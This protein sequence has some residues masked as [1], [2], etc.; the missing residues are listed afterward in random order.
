MCGITGL[1][2]FKEPINRQIIEAMT[3][4]L[5][6][7]GPD[8]DGI[9][10]KNNIA[11]GHRRLAIID[12]ATGQQPLCNE[13]ETV[14]VTFNGEIYNYLDLRQQL[15]IAGHQFRTQSDTEVI[16]HAYE[17]WG[18][19]CV[20]KFRG[21]FAFGIVD[22]KQQKLFLARDQLGI[23]PLYYLTTPDCFAFASELQALRQ[24][25]VN[26]DIDVQA[27]DQYLWLQYIPPPKTIFQQIKKLPTA[28][29]ISITF[30]GNLS[31]PQEYWQLDFN[32]NRKKTEKEWLEEFDFILRESIKSHLVSDVPFGAFLSGGVD[33]SATVAY[34]SQLLEQPVKT[35]SIGFEEEE[36]NELNYAE[37]PAKLW[38]TE[39]YTEIVKLESL[40]VLLP[41]LVKH[42]GEPF[43]DSSA[44]PTYYVCKMARQHVTMVLSGDGGDECFAGYNT[45]KNWMA[46][47]NREEKPLWK[48]FAYPVAQMLK[49]ERYPPRHP[50]LQSWFRFITQISPD[51]RHQ[52]W[53][54]DYQGLVNQPIEVFVKEN[55]K[56]EDYAWSQKAQYIDIKT[57]LPGSILTKVDVVSM[58]N[59]LEVRTPI[60]D[61]EVF[62]FAATIPEPLNI[63]RNS[64]GDWE[65]KLLFKKLLS[66]YYEQDFLHR[67]KMGFST[68]IEKWFSQK[69]DYRKTLEDRFLSQNSR[70]HQYF[71]P[72]MLKI[73]LQQKATQP[74]WLLLF[75]DEWLAQKL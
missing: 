3:A 6:H 69:G 15:L 10:I 43:G 40:D 36:F 20:E 72:E 62:E 31:E 22:L 56:I 48:R 44:I 27:I 53:Q 12:L 54:E 33:S 14:W 9:F 30:D 46:W 19:A 18:E 37:I 23:K 21:M 8:G 2:N 4:S 73:L 11:I 68:P 38:Q 16:V 26:L 41:K 70:L 64:K 35:F 74:L 50:N 28:H 67:P 39:H 51:I 66:R 7:R 63:A 13:D 25:P 65:G 55:P 45:H 52:L 17:E 49:P 58:M 34:M 42:Y 60:V 61:L 71:K 29:R 59:S 5:S 57:Y 47:L 75:L 24:I 32:P 1:L